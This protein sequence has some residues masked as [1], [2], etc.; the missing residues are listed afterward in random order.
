LSEC[1]KPTGDHQRHRSPHLLHHLTSDLPGPPLVR[2][3]GEG[4]QE[5]DR[6]GLHL[7]VDQQLPNALLHLVL[8]ERDDRASEQVD[9]LGDTPG[10]LPGHQRL[11]VLA[12]LHVRD[13]GPLIVDEG[14]RAPALYHHVLESPGD[15]QPRLQ[16]REVDQRVQHAGAGVDGRLDVLAEL[17]TIPGHVQVHV[18]KGLFQG[19]HE[20]DALVVG[21]GRGLADYRAP[22][23]VDHDHIG[24]GAAGVAS[25]EI[26]GHPDLV[27]RSDD[28]L[29]IAPSG[30]A[31][32]AI[33][34]T[35]GTP[36]PRS[37][38]RCWHHAV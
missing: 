21:R 34:T 5:E 17:A 15:N 3:V 2:G 35:P 7:L 22:L 38:T 27:P 24:H 33:W 6:Q 30:R 16:P 12:V 1:W 4:V 37:P 14:L 32:A 26:A 19:F 11:P 18:V 36:R 25:Y 10:E 20:A 28:R 8:V 31:G 29:M 13:L 23:L 9:P